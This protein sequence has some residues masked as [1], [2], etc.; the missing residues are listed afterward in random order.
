MPAVSA[1][2]AVMAC[3]PFEST[4]VTMPN[5]PV[6]ASAV[7]VP[8]TV[9]PLLSYSVTALPGSAVPSILTCVKLVIPSPWVPLSV[10]ASSDRPVGAAG[11]AVSI[12][13]A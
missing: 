12:L 10:V 5:A 1:A 7:P 11:A 6:V 13:T 3:V 2:F 8:S 4:D 9:V